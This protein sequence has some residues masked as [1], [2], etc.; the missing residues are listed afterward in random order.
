VIVGVGVDVVDIARF[1]RVL[2][3]TPTIR[4]RLFT[5]V[6]AELP[7]RSLAARFAAKEAV[8]KALGAPGGLAWHDV[9]IPPSEGSMPV[10]CVRGSVAAAAAARGVERWHVSLS[11]DGGAALAMVVAESGA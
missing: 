4:S 8:A 9:E 3:R 6:E 5:A 7:P 2:A 10:L 11:H 1:E